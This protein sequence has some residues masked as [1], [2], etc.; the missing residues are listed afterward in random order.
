VELCYTGT[1][2]G[3]RKALAQLCGLYS[4]ADRQGKSPVLVLKSRSFTNDSGGTT[5]WPVFNKPINWEFFEPDT[6][7]PPV[8]PIAVNIPPP[9]SLPKPA[10]DLNDEI[11]F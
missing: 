9:P 1:G 2:K 4:R 11:P 8:R 6:P 5:V 3:A 7:A 10:G